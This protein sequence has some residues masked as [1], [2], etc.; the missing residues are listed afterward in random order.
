[1][2]ALQFHA[3]R[4]LRVDDVAEP[5]SPGPTQVTVV[6]RWCGICGTDLHE[7]VAGPIVTSSEPHPLTGAGLPQIL[8]HEFSAEIVA[9][10][11]EVTRVQVGDRVSV[12]PLVYCGKCDYCRR[13]LQHLCL[14]MACTGLSDSWGGIAELAML[15]EYQV[16]RIPDEVTDEQAAVIE[17]CAVAA[18]GVSRGGIKPGDSV[19]VT[20]AGP[21]GTL[22]SL[23]AAAAGAG[24]IYIS[25]LNAARRELVARIGSGE[26]FDPAAVDI[27]GELRERTDGLGVDVAIECSG[28]S[29]A[30]DTCVRS[31]RRGGTIV[32]I[33]LHVAPAQVELMLLAVNDLTIVGT[34][35]YGVNDWPRVTAQ[36]A[37]GRLPVERI[38]TG[39]TSI[40]EVETAFEQLSSGVA[41]DMKVLV[42]T[43][44]TPPTR[45]WEEL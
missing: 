40:D 7:Y 31:V 42:S 43:A 10:G 22:A 6:P 1:M 29:E 37:A 32:Q 9:V 12:M 33:G 34:W 38:V 21:I 3:A 35:C 25:E 44:A 15:E 36:I 13:G 14:S 11:R 17:P 39:R 19:L 23:C 28:D 24:A 16:F 41:S 8:G 30:L 45:L 26:V 5:G 18:Y 2:K 20:G 4:D 27:P